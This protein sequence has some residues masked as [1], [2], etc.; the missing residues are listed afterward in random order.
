VLSY[1]PFSRQPPQTPTSF[2]L[3]KKTKADTGQVQHS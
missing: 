3:T 2:L 1:L